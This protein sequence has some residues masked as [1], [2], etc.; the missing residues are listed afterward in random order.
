MYVRETITLHSLAPD[1]IPQ[2][3]PM[4]AWNAGENVFFRNGET[5]RAFGDSPTLTGAETDARTA[6]YVK[7]GD[8]DFWVYATNDG[9]Y[10]HDGSV[11]YDITPLSG[12]TGSAD[13]TFTSCV[14]NGIAI[15]NASDRDPVYWD[16]DVLNPCV[17]LPD[18]PS[19]GRCLALRSH[20]NFLFAIGM[21]SEGRQ[22][23]RW[24]DAA[25]VG[26]VPQHWTPAED[27]FAGFVDL[28]P[29]SSPCLE[30]KTLRDSFLVY[31][32]ESI[33]SFDLVGGNR[34][35][36]VRK[37][38][39]EH[40]IVNTNAI[41][42]GMDDVH[43]FVGA[44]GD[45]YLTDGTQ[46]TSVLDGRA[47]RAFYQD[48]TQ[49]RGGL[50]A[51]ATLSREK[52]GIIG[53]PTAGSPYIDRALL[54]DFSSGDIGFRDMPDALCISEG[55]RLTDVGSSNIWDGDSASWD[56]DAT[57]WPQEVTGI[58]LDDVIVGGAFGFALLSD[59]SASDFVSGPVSARLEKAGLS[60]GNPRAR[61]MVSRIWPKITGQIGDTLSIRLGGQEI[62][63]GPISLSSPVTFTIGQDQSV[64]TFVQGR[65]LSIEITSTGG[66]PWRM[67]SIDIEYREV[68]GW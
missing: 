66:A 10:A 46:V 11:E 68:G 44:D 55:G 8:G 24:S 64:D 39:A 33:W 65:F 3:A 25:E 18:W 13:E 49:N 23:V 17:A 60:F 1:L 4:E 61:K 48:F 53:Y 16:G 62:T 14:L 52:L 12:W 7:V 41:T 43:L 26:A 51:A 67:G 27:N 2:D 36:Q 22:R 54:F 20:K 9:I 42:G 50:F 34:V 6:C 59:N 57:P 19:G 47:Q 58:T 30:G 38:F 15:F 40:G 56:S 45:V 37:L 35:F 28:S 29:L 31:K 21:V 32:N 5:L 63:G